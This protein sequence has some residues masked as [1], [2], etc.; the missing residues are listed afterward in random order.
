VFSVAFM[1]DNEAAKK[2]LQ[3]CASSAEHYFDASDPE[4]LMA[5]FSGIA[6][7]LSVVRLAR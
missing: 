1:V 5:A 4:K 3:D 6:R 7:S 2:T